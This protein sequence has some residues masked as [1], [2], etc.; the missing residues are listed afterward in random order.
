MLLDAVLHLA[1]LRAKVPLQCSFFI[2]GKEFWQVSSF[3][4]LGSL[5]TIDGTDSKSKYDTKQRI[6]KAKTVF[7]DM[8]NV[9]LSHRVNF[10]TRL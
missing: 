9:L 3:L 7:G 2:N 8:K 4:C 10:T 6:G 1:G 5:I